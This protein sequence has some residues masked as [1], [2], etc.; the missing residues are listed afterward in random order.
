MIAPLTQLI[1]VILLKHA[2]NISNRFVANAGLSSCLVWVARQYLW[3]T[4]RILGS[5]S[6]HACSSPL[7]IRSAYLQCDRAQVVFPVVQILHSGTVLVAVC[8]EQEP[9]R[10]ATLAHASPTQNHQPNALHVGHFH[11]LSFTHC[12]CFWVAGSLVRL[13]AQCQSIVDSSTKLHLSH[14]GSDNNSQML[15]VILSRLECNQLILLIPLL[16]IDYCMARNE[17]ILCRT[18]KTLNALSKCRLVEKERK[19]SLGLKWGGG[20]G[21]RQHYTWGANCVLWPSRHY[22]AVMQRRWSL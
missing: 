15:L 3:E 10:N 2:L 6:V 17:K 19:W 20:W 12:L 9:F 18:W 13:W 7:H 22:L 14:L 5:A 1:P 21:E 4:E 8:F 16:C 11:L